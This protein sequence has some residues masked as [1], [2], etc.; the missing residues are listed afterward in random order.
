MP[1]DLNTTTNEK[2][3]SLL[4][5]DKISI[6]GTVF[7]RNGNSVERQ[8]MFPTL[9]NVDRYFDFLEHL[10]LRTSLLIFLLLALYRIIDREWKKR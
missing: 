5:V 2:L 4:A 10:A 1:V 8:T 7:E 3:T 9:P 6:R